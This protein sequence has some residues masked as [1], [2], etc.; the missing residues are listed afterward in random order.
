MCAA[1]IATEPFGLS[2]FV[3]FAVVGALFIYITRDK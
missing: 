1:L 2:E 3:V